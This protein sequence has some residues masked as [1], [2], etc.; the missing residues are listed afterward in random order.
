MFPVSVANSSIAL[1][2]GTILV[3]VGSVWVGSVGS[4]SDYKAI[5]ASQ[6]S[7]SFGLTEMGKNRQGLKK[8]P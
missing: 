7:W 1:Q 6:Q 8:V 5:S 4:N 3:W 2:I